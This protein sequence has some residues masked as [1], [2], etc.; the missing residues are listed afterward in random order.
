M[1]RDAENGLIQKPAA[2]PVAPV[3][4]CPGCG[5]DPLVITCQEMQLHHLKLLLIFCGNPAC[6]VSLNIQLLAVGQPTGIVLPGGGLP[7][8]H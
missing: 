4:T 6:R 3:P 8:R 2:A 7:V 5:A 1:E